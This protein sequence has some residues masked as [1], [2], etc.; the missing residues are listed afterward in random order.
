MDIVNKISAIFLA[1]VCFGCASKWQ[2]LNNLHFEQKSFSMVCEDKSYILYVNDEF[3]FVLFDSL[4][5]LVVSKKLENGEFKNTKFL[6]PNAKFD[7]I[8]I[9]VL[10]MIKKGAKSA[11]IETQNLTCKAVEI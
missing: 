2:V 1:F 4:L 3:K 11:T 7:P 9:G 6:P 10:E 5:V 8:F